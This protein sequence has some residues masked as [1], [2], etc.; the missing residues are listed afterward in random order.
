[1]KPEYLDQLADLADPDKLWQLAG[2]D[3]LALPE[4]KKRQL[5]T[6]VALRRYASHIRTLQEC[7]RIRCSL[8]I[9][10]FSEASSAWMPVATP[11]EHERSREERERGFGPHPWPSAVVYPPLRAHPWSDDVSWAKPKLHSVGYD[12]AKGPDRSFL[13]IVESPC[14]E[15]DAIE[16]RDEASGR[17]LG[18]IENV[19][20]PAHLREEAKPIAQCTLCQRR[21]WAEEAETPCGMIQPNGFRC[22]GT[23]KRLGGGSR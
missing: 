19:G 5:D 9:T 23:M 7:G 16:F 12:L 3:Q 13:R 10:P 14:V 20:L 4:D 6:G 8:L 17:L 1:M 15:P 21:T 11:P 22:L 2:V 18:R